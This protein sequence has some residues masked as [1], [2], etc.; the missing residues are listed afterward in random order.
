M[1]DKRK[2]EQGRPYVVGRA[3]AEDAASQGKSLAD[4][5][6][7]NSGHDESVPVVEGQQPETD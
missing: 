5:V 3:V 7:E 4:A 1:T 6:K 2:S